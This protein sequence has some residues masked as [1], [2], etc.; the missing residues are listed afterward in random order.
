MRQ[1]RRERK[2]ETRKE[3]LQVVNMYL[4]LCDTIRPEWKGE[5]IE[6]LRKNIGD[7]R[8]NLFS[9]L[10]LYGNLSINSGEENNN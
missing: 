5:H 7:L 1:I 6:E 10:E 4:F 3:L 2:G 8:H 9:L